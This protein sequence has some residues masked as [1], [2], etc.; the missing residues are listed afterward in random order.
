MEMLQSI[1]LVLLFL[2]VIKSI[3]GLKAPWEK[4]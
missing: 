2:V 3:L 1:T 4:K